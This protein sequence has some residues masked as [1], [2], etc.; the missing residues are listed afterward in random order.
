MDGAGTRESMIPLAIEKV[1]IPDLMMPGLRVEEPKVRQICYQQR[2][3][4]WQMRGCK[5]FA[6]KQRKDCT[7]SKTIGKKVF[8]CM[9]SSSDNRYDP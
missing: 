6:H 5:Y 4:H 8:G 9:S 3:C 1:L 2:F 7:S